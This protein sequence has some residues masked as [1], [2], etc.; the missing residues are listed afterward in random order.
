[1]PPYAADFRAQRNGLAVAAELLSAK[2]LPWH[3]TDD[4]MNFAGAPDVRMP[5][6]FPTTDGIADRAAGDALQA[7]R[8]A[9]GR[10]RAHARTLESSGEESSGE[11][12]S[13]EESSGEESSGEES[14]A[15][16]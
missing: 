9:A 14:A 5:D 11:E 4:I 8:E 1:V 3:L 13:G 7:R 6:G 10:G 2:N 12:S 16:Q 15:A